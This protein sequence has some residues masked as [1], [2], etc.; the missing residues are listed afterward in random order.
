MINYY[1]KCFRSSFVGSYPVLLQFWF[2]SSMRWILVICFRFC[3][4][5]NFCGFRLPWIEYWPIST[6]VLGTYFNYWNQSMRNDF[7][8][9]YL[10]LSRNYVICLL[11]VF[12]ICLVTHYLFRKKVFTRD[13]VGNSSIRVVQVSSVLSKV[14]LNKLLYY[15]Y[16]TCH[17]VNSNRGEFPTQ[18]EETNWSF[19]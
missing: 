11:S 6:K 19:H 4:F 7:I 5:I 2:H 15:N 9:Y 10:W 18:L 3:A 14:G 12:C 8:N 16:Y 17:S 13:A 1:T